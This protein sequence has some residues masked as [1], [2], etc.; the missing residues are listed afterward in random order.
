VVNKPFFFFHSSSYGRKSKM[1]ETKYVPD[2][3]A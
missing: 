2:K 3:R 1:I